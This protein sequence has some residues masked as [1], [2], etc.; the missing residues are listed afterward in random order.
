VGLS[1]SWVKA[2][3]M[4]SLEWD[5]EDLGRQCGEI[6]ERMLRGNLK[7][8]IDYAAPRKAAYALNLNTARQMKIEFPEAIVRGA[9]QVF[10][11]GD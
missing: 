9:K 6:A 11:G 2:G 10:S 4:Y 3:A 5:F 1:A 7:Q 8:G